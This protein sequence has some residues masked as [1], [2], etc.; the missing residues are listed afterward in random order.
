MILFE[1]MGE[2][3]IFR[4]LLRRERLEI[5]DINLTPV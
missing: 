3:D 2:I 5:F 4:R 1:A